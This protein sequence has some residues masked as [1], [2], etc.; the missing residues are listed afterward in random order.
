MIDQPDSVEL[1]C[2]HPLGGLTTGEVEGTSVDEI[3]C[4]GSGDNRES[5]ESER[6]SAFPVSYLGPDNYGREQTNHQL[7]LRISNNLSGRREGVVYIMGSVYT[8]LKG[9]KGRSCLQKK[10]FDTR[11]AVGTR[12]IWLYCHHSRHG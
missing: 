7:I 10:S 6:L 4:L 11:N 8:Y 3:C 12:D 1:G 9:G 5:Y 2:R